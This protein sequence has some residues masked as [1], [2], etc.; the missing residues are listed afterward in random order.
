MQKSSKTIVEIPAGG[1]YV[2]N[3]TKQPNVIPTSDG[4]FGCCYLTIKDG[5]YYFSSPY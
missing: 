3:P 1:F 5:G 2:Y 4:A